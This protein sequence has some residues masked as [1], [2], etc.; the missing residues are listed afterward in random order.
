MTIALLLALVG[1]G[2]LIFLS[3]RLLPTPERATAR[4]LRRAGIGSAVGLS[5][6]V[7][8]LGGRALLATD[9]LG[10]PTRQPVETVSAG[11]S[12]ASGASSACAAP[13]IGAARGEV[14]VPRGKP[15]LIEFHSEHCTACARMAPIVRDLEERCAHGGDT[16][17][18]VTIDDDAGEAL[19]AR[20][21]VRHLP[22]FVGVDS[23][24]EE[25]ERVVGEQPRARLAGLLGD[26]RGEAC[27]AL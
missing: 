25:V 1:V 18:R 4:R 13:A 2:L 9:R 22:T 23:A 26:V 19:A 11:G 16:I 6:I 10:S 27:E 5:L 24:G 15:R 12:C 17:L 20:Y 21:G 14:D 7:A 3:P 8:A